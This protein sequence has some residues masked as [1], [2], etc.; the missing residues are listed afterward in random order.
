MLFAAA[1][2]FFK[3]YFKTA[4]GLATACW[5]IKNGYVAVLCTMVY[6]LLLYTASCLLKLGFGAHIFHALIKNGKRL[7]K[8]TAHSTFNIFIA[9]SFGI[10][11]VCVCQ[12][13]EHELSKK[14]VAFDKLGGV[15]C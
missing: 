13:R 5:H 11:K 4:K 8:I 2:G 15:F 14:G 10:E 7:F 12:A 9:K 6:S 1:G 3:G